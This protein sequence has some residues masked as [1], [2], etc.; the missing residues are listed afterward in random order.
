MTNPIISPEKPQLKRC[1]KCGEVKPLDA[2][3]RDKKGQDGRC[4][5]CKACNAAYR[6]ATVERRAEY[7]REYYAAN[8]ERRAEYRR[9]YYETPTGR[10]AC[11]AAEHRR[12]AH[13]AGAGGT[14]TRADLAAIRAAQTDKRGRLICWRCG[15]PIKDTPHLDHWIPL[16]RGGS[17]DPGNLHYMHASCNQLKGSKHP[18]EIGRLI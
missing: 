18:T 15:K 2:F 12:R 16:S 7:Q 9:E 13:M 17:N 1:S 4:A 5:H 6:A 14:Y 11:I 8:A 3:S 10:V